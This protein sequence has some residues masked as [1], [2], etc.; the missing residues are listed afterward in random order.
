MKELVADLVGSIDPLALA[1]RVAEQ[2]CLLLPDVDGAVVVV[3]RDDGPEV[4]SAHGGLTPLLGTT[5]PAHLTLAGGDEV[6]DQ[7]DAG[8]VLSTPLLRNAVVFGWVSIVSAERGAL[9]GD[10]A[11]IMTAA[12]RFIS[13]ILTADS[14]LATQLDELL[15]NTP[16]VVEPAARFLAALVAPRAAAR[17][18]LRA[19]IE[20]ISE[21]EQL[22][23]VFQPVRNLRDMQII[24]YEGLCR[25]ADGHKTSPDQWFAKAHLVGRGTDLEI[26]ALRVVLAAARDIP[27]QFEISVNLSPTTAIQ[28]AAQQLL[29]SAGRRITLELTEYEQVTDP[30]YPELEALRREGIRLA[31]DDTGA[32]FSNLNRIL[33]LRP[34]VI[35]FDRELTVDI[36]HD[37][38]RQA[39]A[40]ALVYFAR[41]IGALTVAEGIENEEQHRVLRDL[42]IHYGQGFFLGP[43][44][45][46]TSGV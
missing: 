34:E 16:D 7:H 44:Q 2:A 41:E 19:E 4:V 14:A 23:A 31:V 11:K 36:H 10:H 27:R 46:V 43:P 33:R 26:Q 25:F 24:G 29:R 5:P 32:G 3:L 13:T 28:P 42:G 21:A 30:M 22:R 40:T 45:P 20:D 9:D 6:A 12:G 18:Q 17:R 39:L 37:P 1:L 15:G 35:K 38:A 8:S